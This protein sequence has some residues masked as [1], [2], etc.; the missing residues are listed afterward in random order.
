MKPTYG[1]TCN[2]LRSPVCNFAKVVAKIYQLVANQVE[3]PPF[4]YPT[5]ITKGIQKMICRATN[6]PDLGIIFRIAKDIEQKFLPAKYF[7]RFNKKWLEDII[8]VTKKSRYST[9][10]VNVEITRRIKI[11]VCCEKVLVAL[12]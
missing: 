4:G 5:M 6:C 3:L 7:Y 10:K 8:N 12:S 11:G 9:E 1:R 2:F